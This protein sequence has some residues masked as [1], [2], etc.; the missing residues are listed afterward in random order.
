M[1]PHRSK[2]I[3]AALPHTKERQ[4][5]RFWLLP[6]AALSLASVASA[7]QAAPTLGTLKAA[8]SHETQQVSWRWYGNWRH[9]LHLH[10]RHH[11]RHGW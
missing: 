5:K 3:D 6:L 9:Y 4:M 8:V 1:A 10:R 2:A 7:A 11:H